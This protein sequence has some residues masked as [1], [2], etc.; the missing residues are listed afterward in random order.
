MVASAVAEGGTAATARCPTCRRSLGHLQQLGRG[1]DGRWRARTLFST[2]DDFAG[3]WRPADSC[4]ALCCRDAVASSAV[5]DVEDEDA[6]YADEADE[7]DPRPCCLCGVDD[8]PDV[9]LECSACLQT[10][11]HTHCLVPRLA[12]PPAGHWLCWLCS[13]ELGARCPSQRRVDREAFVARATAGFVAAK[14]AARMRREIV[15]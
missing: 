6:G 15:E 4:G 10:L 3:G 5:Q 9:L 14:A 12:S 11:A 8:A 13:A 7:V 1:R 2:V